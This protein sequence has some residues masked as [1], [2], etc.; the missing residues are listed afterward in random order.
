MVYGGLKRSESEVITNSANTAFVSEITSKDEFGADYDTFKN[1]VLANEGN[2]KYSVSD[3]EYFLEYTSISGDKLKIDYLNNERYLNDEK[4]DFGEY[5]LFDNKYVQSDWNSDL[6]SVSYGDN[7]LEIGEYKIGLNV[8]EAIKLIK[9][10]D[11]LRKNLEYEE[12]FG[13]AGLFLDSNKA[14]FVYYFEKAASYKRSYLRDVVT[15]RLGMLLETI[16]QNY[17]KADKKTKGSLELSINNI[18]AAIAELTN[19]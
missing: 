8:F 12:K 15:Q 4:V 7:V 2:I 19:L 5:K 14:D 11:S 9:E 10:I 1:K 17:E 16:N 3:K 13:R 6:V 18:N